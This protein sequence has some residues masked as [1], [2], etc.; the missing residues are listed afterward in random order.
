MMEDCI[1]THSLNVVLSY[2]FYILWA[3]QMKYSHRSHTN[4]WSPAITNI[5]EK[6]LR[7]MIHKLNDGIYR[8][9]KGTKCRP[10]VVYQDRLTLYLGENAPEWFGK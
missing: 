1:S 2:V 7:N 4:T 9:Q 5:I 8:I 10:K 3:D 6:T